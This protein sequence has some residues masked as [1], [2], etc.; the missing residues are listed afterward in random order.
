[1]AKWVI[2]GIYDATGLLYVGKTENL[3]ERWKS[4][5]INRFCAPGSPLEELGQ[6]PA[7]DAAAALERRMIRRLRP[8][9][10]RHH[11]ACRPIVGRVPFR[12][13]GGRFTTKIMVRAGDMLPDAAERYWRAAR[14]GL[15]NA[16]VVAQ[17]PG[18]SVG[19]AIQTFGARSHM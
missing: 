13:V 8:K 18:W 4:H 3:E 11:N 7:D 6:A 16:Q 17:M 15:S 19:R 5:R 14:G 2:Y 9:L 10:N 12:R 1:M